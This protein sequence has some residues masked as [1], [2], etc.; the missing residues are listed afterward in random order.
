MVLPSAAQRSILPALPS[1]MRRMRLF[2][3]CMR[4]ATTSPTSWRTCCRPSASQTPRA[5]SLPSVAISCVIAITAMASLL[6][7]VAVAAARDVDQLGKQGP[8]EQEER[9]RGDR[10]DQLVG[11]EDRQVALRE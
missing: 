9:Q 4:P 6:R 8:E 10:A 5:T 2:F 1:R 11:E 3:T 7:A